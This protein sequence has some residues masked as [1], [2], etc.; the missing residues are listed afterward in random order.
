[1]LRAARKKQKRE[2]PSK[3]S[4]GDGSISGQ[5]INDMGSFLLLPAPFFPLKCD[6]THSS[7]N[8]A[9]KDNDTSPRLVTTLAAKCLFHLLRVA[10]VAAVVFV[11]DKTRAGFNRASALAGS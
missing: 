9:T 2:C 4:T 5:Q 11:L 3:A 10:H 6:R 8:Q 1:M 7:G